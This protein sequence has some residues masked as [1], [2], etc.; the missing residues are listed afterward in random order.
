MRPETIRSALKQVP[1]RKLRVSL[2]DGSSHE[3]PHPDFAFVMQHEFLIVTEVTREGVPRR[4]LRVDPLHVTLI[5]RAPE[6][7]GPPANGA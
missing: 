4:A 6:P 1:F 2:S 5:E 3:I 7:D